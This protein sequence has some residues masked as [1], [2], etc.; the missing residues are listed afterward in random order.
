M[1]IKRIMMD[2]KSLDY[3][4]L[5][6]QAYKRVKTMILTDKLL[7]GQ[8]IIQEKL[9]GELGISRMP[10]HRAF[11]MLENELLVEHVPRKGVFVKEVDLY[12]IADAFECREAVEGLAARRAAG[13]I[14]PEEVE[15]LY[16]L[17]AP[18]SENPQ[19]ADLVKYEEADV[20]FHN[21]IIRI[22]GNIILQ[23]ME[24]LGNVIVRTYQRGLIRGPG[25]T[26]QE[27][28]GVIDALSN[29]DSEK[30]ELLL[31]KHFQK[32]R[33]RILRRMKSPSVTEDTRK[34]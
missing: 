28:M 6:Y 14:T 13:N 24:I 5:S 22:S 18:F 10:L 7:P 17:F 8:K 21:T 4:D 11:Q 3:F 23:K 19:N 2:K 31:R 25:E 32:S 1:V 15:F 16:S 9:A 20:I 12:E 34:L 26:Y 29:K 30:A 27:H 33:E